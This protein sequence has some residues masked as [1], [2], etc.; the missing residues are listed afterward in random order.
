MR[1]GKEHNLRNGKFM[2]SCVGTKVIQADPFACL[3]PNSVILTAEVSR[4]PE[5]PD[6][7]ELQA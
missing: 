2:V 4:V 5:T 6:I 7:D 3:S 1:R